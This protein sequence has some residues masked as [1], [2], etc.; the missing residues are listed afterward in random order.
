MI[1]TNTAGLAPSKTKTCP[2][3]AAPLHISAVNCPYCGATFGPAQPTKSR[4]VAIL[5]ALLLGGIGGH[6]FYLGRIGWGFL[7]L[8]FFWTL[9][10]GIVAIIE[11]IGYALMSDES[12]HKK[13]G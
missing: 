2:G 10:P 8:V 13:Y 11:T 7:Y 5:L 1:D 9:V 4:G 3:C 12:F 6:K